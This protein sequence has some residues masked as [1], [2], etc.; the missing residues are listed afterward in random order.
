MSPQQSSEAAASNTRSQ[1]SQEPSWAAVFE[2]L[3]DSERHNSVTENAT[4]TFLGESFPLAH[5][6]DGIAQRGGIHMLHPAATPEQIL[7]S[8]QDCPAHLSDED[9]RY[10]A[11]KGCL[12]M[13]PQNHLDAL[14]PT[15]VER[16]YPLYPVVVLQD[17]LD[18]AK[19]GS[20]PL[21]LVNAVC[22]A[23]SSFCS[24]ADLTCLGF[25]S[26][27]DARDLFYRRAKLLFDFGYESNKLTL[28]QSTC[29]MTFW[30]SGPRDTWTFYHWIGFSVTLAESLG[31]HRSLSQVHMPEKDRSLLKRIWYTLVIRDAWGAAL[32][33]RPFRI[34]DRQCDDDQLILADFKYDGLDWDAA[35]SSKAKSLYFIQAS[36][37]ALVLRR[38]FG[39]RSY[40]QTPMQCQHTSIEDLRSELAGWRTSVPHELDWDVLGA[41][42]NVYA[43][44]LSL[45][46]H[47]TLILA[48]LPVSTSPSS[49][50]TSQSTGPLP[51]LDQGSSLA[52]VREGAESIL[53]IATSLVTRN[54]LTSVPHELFTGI[55]LAHVLL[56]ENTSAEEH[57][58]SK[59]ARAQTSCFQMV[60]HQIRDL[61]EPASWIIHLIKMLSEKSKGAQL[62]VP[63]TQYDWGQD[64]AFSGDAFMD[65]RHYLGD[66]SI[67]D[68]ALPSYEGW[69][70]LLG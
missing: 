30:P 2:T 7:H 66:L 20:L 37:L 39:L 15:F 61:W 40:S 19:S 23:A 4:I 9:I 49:S 3:F 52:I 28:L 59:L 65:M 32:F 10:L 35:P 21:V 42:T 70:G 5:L 68:E 41:P 63:P 27:K 46:Y 24:L 17:F 43:G 51:S 47:N 44:V 67:F 31:I 64:D 29:L 26:R 11:G 8:R 56:Y 1:V 16:V 36:S 53:D 12:S 69:N 25:V 57:A 34:N 48:H 45:L 55:F 13:P 33:G 54:E 50:G 22:C 60:F 62:S 6:L 58:A 14:L 18:E 38:V